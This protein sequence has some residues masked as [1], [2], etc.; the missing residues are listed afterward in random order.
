LATQRNSVRD[1][2]DFNNF[3]MLNR[4]SGPPQ[5]ALLQG[6]SR[7]SAEFPLEQRKSTRRTE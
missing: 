7:E 2:R 1:L 4:T 3:P 6:F 5:S